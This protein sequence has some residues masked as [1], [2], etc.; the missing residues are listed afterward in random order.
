MGTLRRSKVL[1]DL[2]HDVA[3][4]VQ[5][6]DRLGLDLNTELSIDDLGGSDTGEEHAI[7]LAGEEVVDARQLLDDLGVLGRLRHSREHERGRAAPE[8]AQL[9]VHLGGDHE[10]VLDNAA[11]LGA[12]PDGTIKLEVGTEL[13]AA[14]AQMN[15]LVNVEAA[16]VGGDVLLLGS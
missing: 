1:H 8:V 13:L 7:V 2:R 9:T 6:G 11:N 16:T 10:V 12:Q 3:E 15:L 4:T 5:L 14:E